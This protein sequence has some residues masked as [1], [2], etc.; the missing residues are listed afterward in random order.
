MSTGAVAP[1]R[2]REVAAEHMHISR[3]DGKGSCAACYLL[4]AAVEI[5]QLRVDNDRLEAVVSGTTTVR[6]AILAALH[7]QRSNDER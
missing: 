1:E 5:E 3:L 4:A 6:G 7:S 2:L